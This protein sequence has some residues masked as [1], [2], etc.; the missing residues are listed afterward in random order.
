MGKLYSIIFGLIL[1][2]SCRPTA[3][4]EKQEKVVE[5]PGEVVST[6]IVNVE[7][8]RLRA[9]PGEDG[10]VLTTLEKG[11]V[12]KD[13]GEASKFYTEVTLRGIPYKEPWIK[14][15][16][17]DS[18]I[19][20]TFAG[21]L[22]FDLTYPSEI[23]I[24]L[25]RKRLEYLFGETL[26][27]KIEQYRYQYNSAKTSREFAAAFRT[28]K[29][30][31]DSLNKALEIRFDVTSYEIPPDLDWLNEPIPGYATLLVAEGT[32]YYLFQNYKAMLPKVKATE[33]AEDNEFIELNFQVYEQDSIENFYPVWFMQT[34]D[35]GGHSL[36]GRGLHLRTLEEIEE[37]L[38]NT[39]LF[40]QEIIFIKTKLLEDILNSENTYWESQEKILAELEQ[41]LNSN[42]SILTADETVALI[43]RKTMFTAPAD[44]GIRLDVKSEA[45]NY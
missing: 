19:G 42:F 9:K 33:G 18:I 17:P 8:L 40:E 23:A 21:G 3:G 39:D 26:T 43:A 25:V 15:Q 5:Q 22:N 12:L 13:L 35:Y 7:N 36:L 16:T 30:L 32:Q 45:G 1:I 34:W 28:G 37:I 10:E 29:H 31:R 14:V 4:E 27:K 44:N 11:T 38:D 20:W 24:Q 2:I 6:M 41:V